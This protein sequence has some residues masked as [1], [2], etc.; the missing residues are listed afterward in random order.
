MGISAG[1]TDAKVYV[2]ENNWKEQF[3]ILMFTITFMFC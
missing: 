1:N 3:G 2:G